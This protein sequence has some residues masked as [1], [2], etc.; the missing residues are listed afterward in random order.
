MNQDQVKGEL[1][2]LRGELAP[3]EVILSGKKSR[4]VNGLYRPDTRQIILHNRNFRDDNAL[5]YT[6]IHELAHHIQFTTAS[7]PVSVRSHTTEFW[8]LLHAL[9]R[10]AEEK[11]IYRNVFTTIPEFEELTGRIKREILSVNGSLMKKLGALL[12]QAMELC[13]R[14]Q[15]SF[16]DYLDRVLNLPRSSASLIMKV[17]TMDLRPEIGF[18]NM[19]TVTR[20]RDDRSRAEAQEELL[21]GQSSYE[22]KKKYLSREEPRDPLEKLVAERERVAGQIQRLSN[23]L[24]EIEKRIAE[25]RIAER[26]K[27]GVAPAR[28]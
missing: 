26:E 23:R 3:F 18:E 14:H 13:E 16:G 28:S 12:L 25:K 4:K 2:K 21:E 22:I 19:R 20:I 24:K 8:S 11:G 15:A 5:L 9:L 10:E 1:L 7:V 6:A 27:E 17:H